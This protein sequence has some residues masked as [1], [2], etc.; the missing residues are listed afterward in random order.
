MGCGAAEATGLG[1]V[2]LLSTHVCCQPWFCFNQFPPPPPSKD[3]DSEG[4]PE[5]VVKNRNHTDVNE[6]V[7]DRPVQKG[8][9]EEI[10]QN[11]FASLWLE[12]TFYVTES[13]FPTIHRR[14]KIVETRIKEVSMRKTMELFDHGLKL[15]DLWFV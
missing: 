5:V 10:K 13:A 15:N 9:K 14:S 2:L 8:S 1:F 6:F 11:E 3:V 12:K 4:L 7:Y